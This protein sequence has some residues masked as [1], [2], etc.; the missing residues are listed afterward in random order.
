MKGSGLAV[1]SALLLILSTAGCA[2]MENPY[3]QSGAVGG[4]AGAGIG[5][6]TGALIGAAIANGDVA[7]SAA[8]GGAI[9]LPVGILVGLAW[10]SNMESSAIEKND[11]IIRTNYEYIM[12]RQM[13]IDRTRERLIEESFKILPDKRM[14]SDIYTGA[15]IGTYNR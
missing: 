12:T 8:L 14:R 2:S 6:G 4:I 10:R 5:A 13:E 1:K 7:M 11:A 3:F 9:G 15:T